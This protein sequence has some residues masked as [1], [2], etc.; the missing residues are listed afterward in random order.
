MRTAICLFTRD[1]RMHDNP[2]LHHAARADRVVPLF[3]FDETLLR[4]PFTRPN[5]IAFLLGCLRDLRRSLG[6]AGGGLV[7]RHGTPAAE[8]ARLVDEVGATEVHVAADVSAYA[9]SRDN[10]LRLALADR[11]CPLHVHEAVVTAHPPGRVTP[12]GKDHFAVFT[13]YFRRWVETPPRRT[14]AAPEALRMPDG[15]RTGPMPA[16]EDLC[17][18]E[19]S[20]DLPRGGET[21]ARQRMLQWFEQG[22]ADYD[23][24]HDD[25][26]GDATSRLSPYLHFG[27]L[28]P[29]EIVARAGRSEPERAFVRQ[30]AWR[31]FHHQ[32]LAARPGCSHLDYRSRGDRWRDD[33]AAFRAWR[34]GRTGIPIVDAG[35][36]QLS[37]EGWMHNRARLIT[38][39][40]LTKTLYL[41]WRLGAQHFFDLL[42]D[43]DVAN[44]A[45][46]WQ[47]VAGTGADTRPNRVLNPMRQAERYDPNGDYIRRYV[48]E[49]AS[50]PTAALHDP[51]RMDPAERDRLGYPAPLVDVDEANAHF[52]NT[53]G[54]S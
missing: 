17:P 28:S 16:R 46:N 36:R 1:L 15:V 10:G 47:W 26:A 32:M 7:V 37:R 43:G 5:R 6:E 50:L 48:P 52:R 12:A 4:L 33:P 41:D 22:V 54:K 21:T 18:G 44:N 27:C 53:R 19:L 24:G 29:V 45:M 2:V 40:F 8:V 39:S 3:V 49:L 38:A 25:L 11:G 13:P 51:R 9:R 42:V 35:M 23:E 30:L 20:P 14:A 31:D 34:D